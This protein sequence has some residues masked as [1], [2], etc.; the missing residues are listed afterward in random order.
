MFTT[1]NE[2]RK[3]FGNAI[4]FGTR[5]TWMFL[6]IRNVFSPFTMKLCR[7]TNMSV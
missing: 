7:G 5:I 3:K 2:L 6:F 4:N 1:S